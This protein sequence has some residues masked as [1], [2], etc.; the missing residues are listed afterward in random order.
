M[1]SKRT[2]MVG[3]AVAGWQA[4][5]R[6]GH[7]RPCK[8]RPLRSVPRRHQTPRDVGSLEDRVMGRRLLNSSW[9]LAS[10]SRDLP[11]L[12]HR[13]PP[14]TARLWGR[15]VPRRGQPDRVNLSVGPSR[16]PSAADKDNITH[17][18]N[19]WCR[20]SAWSCGCW[21]EHLESCR[22]L[23]LWRRG[24]RQLAAVAGLAVRRPVCDRLGIGRDPDGRLV[25]FLVANSE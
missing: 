10:R 3:R 18:P 20:L 15:R 14:A 6:P 8:P 22:R 9:W 25:L 4:Q 24:P 21:H 19:S 2:L 5:D 1:A 16:L 7:A 13:R 23:E 17:M 11:T 12:Q